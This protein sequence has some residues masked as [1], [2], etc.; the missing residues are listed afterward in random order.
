MSHATTPSG[1]VVAAAWPEHRTH[2]VWPTLPPLAAVS[3]EEQLNASRRVRLGLPRSAPV[4]RWEAAPPTVGLRQL[5][6]G[7]GAEGEGGG[8]VVLRASLL[9]G[10]G[11]TGVPPTAVPSLGEAWGGNALT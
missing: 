9:A 3:L 1:L 10:E 5:A 4:S 8:D 11:W 6:E 7:V 2:V